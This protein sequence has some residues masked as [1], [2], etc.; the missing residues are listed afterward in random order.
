MSLHC[1]GGHEPYHGRT[2]ADGHEPS[3]AMLAGDQG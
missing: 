2:P 1:G 3:L